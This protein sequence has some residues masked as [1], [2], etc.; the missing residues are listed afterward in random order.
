MIIDLKNITTVERQNYLQH[1]IAPRPICFASTIGADGQVNLSPFSFFNLFS[2]NPPVVIFSPA[3]RVRDNTTKHTLQ[4]VLEVPEV[5]INIV[6]YDMV[7]QTSLASCE[8]PRNINEF[9]PSG[10]TPEP[11]TLVKPP[12][13][14]ESKVK[15]E[16][17]VLEI[18]PLG[19][20]G[21]AGNLVICEVLRMHIDDSILNEKNF[22]D[23]R[24]LHHVAR[25]G[26]DWYCKVDESNL[27]QVEKPNVKLGIGID[28][29]PAHIRTSKILSGNNLG[30][31]GN[32]HEMPVIDPSFHDDTLKNIFQ[33]YSV[34]PE[35]MEKELH[36]YA[37]H[38]L[39]QGKV[40]D[41][42]QILLA[43]N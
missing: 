12:M 24:K 25:L 6:D 34:N 9:G 31:L 28:A 38:L 29:L 27:F 19:T 15:M 33:Y 13:V 1:A 26:G 21:G 7:Q 40:Q 39:D 14:K 32:V 42:W 8:F 20:E 23:Q 22:I 4:N 37:K 5:V 30:Q 3:R 2:S 10:F 17:H 11:A 35:E 16:C 43:T 18:K 36:T 41:A